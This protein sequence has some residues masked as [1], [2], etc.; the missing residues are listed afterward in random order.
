MTP[1]GKPAA[2]VTVDDIQRLIDDKVPEGRYL[3]YKRDIPISDEEQKHARAAGRGDPQDRS[4]LQKRPL[5]AFGRDKL[6]E[7]LVSF[8]NADGGVLILGMTETKSEPA[9]ADGFNL[10]PDVVGLERRL[11]DAIVDC[12]EPRLPF[13]FVKALPTEPSGEG[14][15]ILETEPSRLGPHRVRRTREATIRREDRC[16]Q[17]TMAEIHDM[18][19][20]NARR[21]DAVGAT[22]EDRAK[23]FHETFLRTLL[24]QTPTTYIPLDPEGRIFSWLSDAGMAAFGLRITLVPHD[25]LG[26]PRLE[27]LTGLVPPQE[28]LLQKGRAGGIPVQGADTAWISEHG[29]RPQ[30]GG[31]Q[32]TG[33]LAAFVLSYCV[34]RD[35]LVEGTAVSWGNDCAVPVELLVG[36][37]ACVLGVYD[38]LR[39]RAGAPSMPAEVGVEILTRGRP[40]V[41][42]V[43][44]APFLRGREPLEP[45]IKFPPLSISDRD[46]FSGVVNAVAGD[47]VNASGLDVSVL[48]KYDVS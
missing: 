18:V 29:G 11:R 2:R 13:A 44:G 14:V 4:W 9:R 42:R 27:R 20:R 47:L 26:V 32:Q 17:M 43:G 48:P 16:D 5:R 38:R 21:F 39:E 41:S 22:L 3:E 25:D 40:I 46:S 1:F 23:L 24:P 34:K 28:S 30:L 19:I 33:Q 12:I 45:M 15:V 6:M 31:V 36:M 37:V 7:E 10:F 8:A 35:G